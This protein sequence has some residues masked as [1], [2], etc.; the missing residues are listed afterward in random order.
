VYPALH[1]QLVKKLLPL[2]VCEFPGQLKQ[3]STE[4][5]ARVVEYVPAWQSRFWQMKAFQ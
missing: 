5:A 3:E 1:R 4:E 2:V